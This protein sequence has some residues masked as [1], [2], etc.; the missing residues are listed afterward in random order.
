Q[1]RIKEPMLGVFDL[2]PMQEILE[3]GEIGD[4]AVMATSRTKNL[5]T[6]GRHEPV[7]DVVLGVGAE[8]IALPPRRERTPHAIS[9]FQCSDHLLLRQITQ[10]QA[11]AL[12]LCILEVERLSAI[13]AFEKLHGPGHPDSCCRSAAQPIERHVA[14]ISSI[15]H[16]AQSPA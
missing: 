4:G 16:A 13:L 5:T 15:P 3:I 10:P 12:A 9:R 8:A 14:V 7:A 6:V 11:A 2:A 1:Q